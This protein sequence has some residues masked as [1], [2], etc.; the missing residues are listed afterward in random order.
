MDQT[1]FSLRSG[2]A[3]G[4]G[5]MMYLVMRFLHFSKGVSIAI[6]LAGGVVLGTVLAVLIYILI[7]V[8][9]RSCEK[10]KQGKK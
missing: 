1:D 6:G 9:G 2:L 8:V 5:I 4:V 7:E 3:A 10:R